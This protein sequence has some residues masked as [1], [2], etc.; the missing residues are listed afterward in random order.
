MKTF[1]LCWLVVGVVLSST[2]VKRAP[3]QNKDEGLSV[4]DASAVRAVLE[5]Y[6]AS[7]LANDPAAVRGCFTQDAVLMPH[8]GIAPI[9]GMAAI[10]EFWWPE[11]TSKTTIMNFSQT[12]AEVD[13]SGDF[14]YARGRSKVAWITTDGSKRETWH[15]GGN[16]MAVFRKAE[17]KWLISRL[18]WDDPPNETGL[19]FNSA[20]KW[21]D[22]TEVHEVISGGSGPFVPVREPHQ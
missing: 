10:K 1:V 9:V 3:A 6:R 13:G 14:A 8:H 5:R 12:L 20:Q 17:G 19:A 18:I 4:S 7:W 11:T 22:P 21:L 16:F 15:N 2:L